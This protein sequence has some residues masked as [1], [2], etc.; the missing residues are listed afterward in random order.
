MYV[1]TDEPFYG[2]SE[3]FNN[4]PLGVLE[5][6]YKGDEKIKIAT[7]REMRFTNSVAQKLQSNSINVKLIDDESFVFL[8]N[9]R[10]DWVTG[11]VKQK[12]DASLSLMSSAK[13]GMFFSAV[14]RRYKFMWDEHYKENQTIF[15]KKAKPFDTMNDLV[16]EHKLIWLKNTLSERRMMF[17]YFLDSIT[18]NPDTPIELLSELL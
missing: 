5:T 1:T 17:D 8:A 16:K 6:F 4:H 15:K 12:H 14:C 9:M 11:I 7:Y 10:V 18:R 3:D 2:I 13:T